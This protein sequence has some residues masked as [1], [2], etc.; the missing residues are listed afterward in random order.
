MNLCGI[1]CIVVEY[2]VTVI[3]LHFNTVCLRFL[4]YNELVAGILSCKTTDFFVSIFQ[5]LRRNLSPSFL[6]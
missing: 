4:D 6:L 1:L 2:K 5:D 3:C